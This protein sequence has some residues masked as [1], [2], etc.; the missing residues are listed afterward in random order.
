[1]PKAP[2]APK[3]ATP[4][5]FDKPAVDPMAKALVSAVQ[6]SHGMEHAASMA[7]AEEIGRPRGFVGT[8]NIAIDRAIASPGIP[9]GRITEISGWEGSGKSTCLDQIIAE[10]Q[11]QGGVG[12]LAD[13]ERARDRPYMV[14]LGVQPDTMVWCLGRTV[15]QMFDE[16]STF[17]RNI[18]S[19][20]AVAWRE[21][22]VRAGASIPPCP[23]Y[24][25]ATYDPHEDPKKKGRKPMAVAVLSRWGREQAAALLQWQRENDLKPSGTRDRASR[26]I[27]RPA[28]LFGD[29][30]DQREALRYWLRDD[31][32]PCVVAA[33]R[34]VVV[35]WDSVGGTATEAEMEGDARAVQV[36]ASAK[37][38]KRNFRRLVQTLDDEA[39]AF[40]IC[41]QRYEKI[42]TT[43]I[44]GASRRK[45]SETY[46]GS[47][48]KYHAG[49]RLELEKVGKFWI[50]STSKDSGDPP[51]GQVTR[52]KVV[53]N[54]I[55]VPDRTEEYGLV[56]G[57]GADNAWAI[58]TDLKS[59]GVIAPA[60]G[61]SRFTDP[62][63]L[64]DQPGGDKNW[65]QTWMGLSDMMA[66]QTNYPG[67]WSKLS[68]LYLER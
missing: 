34:P 67:L 2:S 48:I 30:D 1:M 54:K 37:V 25:L 11:A 23:T 55:G 31:Y 21:A 9:L 18:A 5:V 42:D 52:V 49:V 46:G 64:G 8:R 44:P 19:M 27:L 45:Q 50:N 40:V 15:E 22:L 3:K 61:W 12:M 16:V 68:A 59:R 32:H 43:Y 33:D 35:G 58:F 39:I 26:E 63:I 60:G 6:I 14:K 10:C 29:K 17:S 57:R 47:G 41:N 66:D 53:K 51:I 4:K 13:T 24:R 65:R 20:N 7:M 56:Y 36:A 62:T 28:C 38:I